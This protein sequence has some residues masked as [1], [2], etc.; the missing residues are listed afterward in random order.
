[1]LTFSKPHIS[2]FRRSRVLSMPR[3]LDSAAQECS[4]TVRHLARKIVPYTYFICPLLESRSKSALHLL[5]LWIALQK[6]GRAQHT[7][8]SSHIW[9]EEAR[10]QASPNLLF[11]SSHLHQTWSVPERINYL[12]ALDPHNQTGLAP[13]LRGVGIMQGVGMMLDFRCRLRVT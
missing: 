7:E 1:M 5:I 6:A 8:H 10:L 9:Y 13:S 12:D 2:S 4:H 3:K 11:S